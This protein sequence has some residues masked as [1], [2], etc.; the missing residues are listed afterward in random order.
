MQEL[1]TQ[2]GFVNASAV[3]VNAFSPAVILAA[4]KETNF[5]SCR[6]PHVSAD[7]LHSLHLAQRRAILH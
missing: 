4:K 2:A 5:P 1:S 3:R 6:S 7:Y